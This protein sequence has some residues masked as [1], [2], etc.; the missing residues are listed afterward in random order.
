MRLSPNL[1]RAVLLTHL[2]GGVGWFGSVAA[3]LCL[4]ITGLTTTDP[5]LAQAS[6]LAMDVIGWSVVVPLSA[7]VVLAGLVQGAG[8][9]W[10]VTRH[11][12]VLLK[13]LMTMIA[14]AALLMHMQPTAIL[15]AAARAERLTD[16][17]L[18]GLRFELVLAPSLAL[19]LLAFNAGLGV[20]K[21]KGLTPFA[22]PARNA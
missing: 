7:V 4:S 10:G 14:A 15:A 3:Y 21:P 11:W 1:R 5:Q 18:Q 16:P 20:V 13:L 9:A 19:L 6:Y 8:T 22:P 2:L 17:D 12:W